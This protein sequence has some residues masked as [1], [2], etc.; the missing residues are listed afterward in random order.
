MVVINVAEEHR[1]G[2]VIV[3][4]R[5]RI[6]L[7]IVTTGAVD[8]QT[9]ESLEARPDDVIQVIVAVERIIFLAE[10]HARAYTVEGGR[11]HTI[12]SRLIDLVCRLLL[13]KKKRETRET[14]FQ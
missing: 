6:E 1:H 10:A 8:G 9:H 12:V 4:S 5:K 14:S 11:G 3:G 7:V 13:E 2:S